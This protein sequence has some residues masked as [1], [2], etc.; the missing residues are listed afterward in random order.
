MS[1]VLQAVH[2]L[3][4]EAGQIWFPAVV[5]SP[6]SNFKPPNQQSVM[7]SVGHGAAVPEIAPSTLNAGLFMLSGVFVYFARMART[8][9]QSPLFCDATLVSTPASNQAT[10]RTSGGGVI[11]S[12]M[13]SFVHTIAAASP[14]TSTRR[15][16]HSELG[17]QV[18]CFCL[19]V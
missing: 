13:R 8:F 14:L 10:N 18:G 5:R 15:Q 6:Q 7:T 3:A 1:V 9:W 19:F 16:E 2:F 11:G 4:T 17:K 12:W